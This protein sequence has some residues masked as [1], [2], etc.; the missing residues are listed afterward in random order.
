MKLESSPP[1]DAAVARTLSAVKRNGGSVLVVGPSETAHSDVC[2]LLLGDEAETIAVRTDRATPEDTADRVLERSVPIRSVSA[3]GSSAGGDTK[4]VSSDL[5]REMRDVASESSSLRVC[6][7]SLRPFVDTTDHR[8]LA[9]ELE[10]IRETARETDAVVHFHLPAMREA[11]PSVV[12]EA[13]DA[14]VEVRSQGE[15][16]YQRWQLP[17]EGPTTEWI[18]V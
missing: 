8:R 17:T 10:A 7:D 13:V 9:A 18:S 16:T 11:I 5:R 4:A 14:T 3:S 15:A 6:F 12:F 1:F 2:R